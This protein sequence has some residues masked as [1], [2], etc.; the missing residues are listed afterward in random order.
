MVT[1]ATL[2]AWH[3]HTGAC[4]PWGWGHPVR[5][6]LLARYGL[7]TSFKAQ[8]FLLPA[9]AEPVFADTSL[10]CCSVWD[11]FLLRRYCCFTAWAPSVK[12]FTRSKA[13]A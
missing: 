10:G 2:G 13:M 9:I 11:E 12:R 8:T 6:G 7:V 1:A 5:T 3:S 4:G